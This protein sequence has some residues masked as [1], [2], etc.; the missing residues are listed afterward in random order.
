MSF[1]SSYAILITEGE[2][3]CRP[4]RGGLLIFRKDEWVLRTID[5]RQFVTESVS[6]VSTSGPISCDQSQSFLVDKTPEEEIK[7][8]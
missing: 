1:E 7:D 6:V 3:E 8:N 2:G 4:Y 5:G